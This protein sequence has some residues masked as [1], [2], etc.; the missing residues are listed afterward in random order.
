ML[1]CAPWIQPFQP[2]AISWAVWS[3]NTRFFPCFLYFSPIKPKHSLIY[4]FPQQY[5]YWFVPCSCVHVLWPVARAPHRHTCGSWHLTDAMV[6][7]DDYFFTCRINV[8]IS[9]G[10]LAVLLMYWCTGPGAGCLSSK[11]TQPRIVTLWAAR[12]VF[13]GGS[14]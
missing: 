12:T 1:M 2:S 6:S 14:N 9:S 5:V 7:A 11:W 4:F 3:K 8:Y 10:M 13:L